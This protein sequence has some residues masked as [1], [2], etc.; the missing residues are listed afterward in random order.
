MTKHQ[1]YL[2]PLVELNERTLDRS[3]DRPCFLCNYS[4]RVMEREGRCFKEHIQR[5][6]LLNTW[7]FLLW[8][9]Q[10]LNKTKTHEYTMS[11][12]LHIMTYDN[13]YSP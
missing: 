13:A 11:P 12:K 9:L 7:V 3:A 10:S 6:S 1:D 8:L 4:H 2:F 5:Q